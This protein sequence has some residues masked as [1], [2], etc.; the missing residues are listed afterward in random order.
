ML[1]LLTIRDLPRS[2]REVWHEIFSHY[3]FMRDADP[4]EHIVPERRGVLGTI[5]PQQ[6]AH[7]KRVLAGLLVKG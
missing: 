5:N 4:A 3:V 2:Q 1:S 6:R 7:I